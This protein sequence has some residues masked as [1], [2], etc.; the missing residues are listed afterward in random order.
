MPIWQNGTNNVIGTISQTVKVKIFW[1]FE[2]LKIRSDDVI[3][4]RNVKND[5]FREKPEENQ[6]NSR[7]SDNYENCD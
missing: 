1:Y 3:I 4:P 5:H 6:N 7:D 2:S